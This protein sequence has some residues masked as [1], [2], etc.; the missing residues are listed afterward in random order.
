M[1][2]C[3]TYLTYLSIRAFSPRYFYCLHSM[4]VITIKKKKTTTTMNYLL[5]SN[6][7]DA[8][9][10]LSF[11]C[12]CQCQAVITNIGT[13][14]HFQPSLTTRRQAGPYGTLLFLVFFFLLTRTIIWVSLFSIYI[15]S[16]LFFLPHS[17]SFFFLLYCLLGSFGPKTKNQPSRAFDDKQV[18]ERA[19]VS[20]IIYVCRPLEVSSASQK[21]TQTCFFIRSAVA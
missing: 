15:H 9:T 11:F 21:R 5:I 2:I 10:F 6:H 20:H 19:N 13:H 16:Q 18:K 14:I 12:P 7:I 4:F 17:L 3:Y 1:F 8:Y